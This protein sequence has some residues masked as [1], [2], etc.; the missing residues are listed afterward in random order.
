[1]LAPASTSPAHLALLGTKQGKWCNSFSR[2]P[3]PQVCSHFPRHWGIPMAYPSLPACQRGSCSSH[4]SRETASV[5][6]AKSQLSKTDKSL[7]YEIMIPGNNTEGKIGKKEY[8][9]NANYSDNGTVRSVE[10]Y[11]LQISLYCYL[12]QSKTYPAL[13]FTVHNASM[14]L[15]ILPVLERSFLIPACDGCCPPSGEIWLYSTP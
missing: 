4:R 10:Q 3:A 7:Q 13:S 15:G 2:F 5:V 12:E 14:S 6:C 1:M 11:L 8:Q 9:I